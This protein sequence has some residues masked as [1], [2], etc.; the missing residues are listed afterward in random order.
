MSSTPP[1]NRPDPDD[2]LARIQAQEKQRERG[3]LK[4][5]FGYAAGVGKTYA[6][7]EA[8]HQR[9]AEGIDVVVGYVET[10]QRVETENM[11]QGL[12]VIPPKT[13][14]YRNIDLPEMD[15]DQVLARKPQLV[16]VDELAH[17]NAPGS[18][19]AKRYQDVEELLTTGI[20]VY[21]T[22]NIQH[23][24]SLND[25]VAQITGTKV[26]ET[27]PDSVIDEVTDIELIDLP[28]DELLNR[29][30]EGKVYV[31]EQA[32]RAIEKFF[33]QGN[34][35]ALRELTMRRAAE[36]V[37]D[38]MLSYMET[39]AISGP[40]QAGERLLVC[41]SPGSV[42]ERLIRTARRLADELKAEWSAIYVETPQQAGI[43][44]EQR[45]RVDRMLRLAEDLGAKSI[46]LP[47]QSVVETV[48]NYARSHNVTKIIIGKSRR[49]RWEKLLRN[50]VA[51]ELI[52]QSGP[53]D[54][55][56]VNSEANPTIT[57]SERPWQ[58]HRPWRRYL[59]ATALVAVAT[60]I[61]A[62]VAPYISPTNLVVI[63]LL[64]TV[65][66]AIFLGRG[67]AVLAS[68]LSVAAFDYFFVPP[69]LTLAV[70]D[71]EYI[72]T[73]FGL[74]AVSLVISY[75][76]A[77]V[78]EQA[79]AAQR[80][81]AQTAAL[82]ELGHDLTATVGLEAVAKTII[83]HISQTFSRE[84]AIFLPEGGQLKL[85]SASPGLVVAENELAVATWTFE[86][87]Q[88]AG[89]GTDTLPDASMHY[90][91][92]K[93][94][95]GVIGVLG[96][97]PASPNS[98]MSPDQ[99]RTLDAFVNQVALAIEG[100]RLSEQARQ[101]ELLEAT[102]KLQTALLNSISH[103][104][105]T[106]LVSITGALSSLDEDSPALDEEVRRS[107]IDTAREEAERLNRL[108]G[109]LLDISRLE[110]GAMHLHREACDVQE[111]IGSSLEQIGTPL[112]NRQVKV[113][114]SPK[115]P[116]VD[117]DFVLF[118]RVLVNVI[119]NALKYSAPDKPVEI[120]AHSS[121]QFLDI[122]VADRGEGIPVGDLERIFDKFYRVQRPDNVSGTGLG[123]SISKGI[124]EA[125]GGCIQAAN[126]R[127]GGAII[128][129]RL[130]LEGTLRSMNDIGLR[131]LV[132][133]D[134]R[135]IRRYLHAALNAQGYTVYEASGGK[136]AVNMVVADRPDLI[137][138]DL[139]L[140]DMDGVEV[141]RQLREWTHIPIIVLSVREQESDKIDALDAG[142]DDYLTK[143]FSSGELM[144]R[145]RAALRRSMDP[146][147]EPVFKMD[148]LNVDLSRRQVK[149]SGEEISLTPTEYDLL[150]ILVQ[151][152]G[153]VLTH[154]QLLRQVW[155]AAYESEAHLLRVNMSNLRRK[156]EP[157]PTRPRYIITEPGVGYRLK[158]EA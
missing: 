84:V 31:P 138:L 7:L 25:V 91:P 19:H 50:S 71:T 95:R 92:L 94:T 75:L 20:N 68:V 131:V 120:K 113:D 119:D 82:Y 147:S 34:L 62:L 53:I 23:L 36:R 59:W 114:I 97:K 109:N 64:S 146:A 21:T 1:V 45:D 37:D 27:I 99:R 96:V 140:P 6:M 88:L 9:K 12:E 126:R 69:H 4:I 18:R 22:L 46:S 10:H 116:L 24:E 66:A 47:G 102:E 148:N 143:P 150:R 56:F 15:I 157:D 77:Q 74:L 78:R 42:S 55:Y 54:V 127:G 13:I 133:D 128:T 60:G 2:L 144:A 104:L 40:W 26:R 35:T 49:S 52:R 14:T 129:V 112:K 11:L 33:R 72:L 70:T 73:F 28:T 155:G 156:I 30:K 136:D 107:L 121:S 125:H 5:F 135:A 130:P 29:L 65:L 153:R 87:G 63:Y 51:D 57:Q 100:A 85:Y 132:V 81:E 142:A 139:G 152:A 3:H 158:A 137:I 83:S 98:Y 41:I 141:T 145:M 44:A 111:L 89:R 124:V 110:A 151:N 149:V 117:V 32:E 105:R 108:V 154:R 43:S 79:E 38:Q 17:T 48:T 106:P 67:P 118:S 61:G 134:E 101:T 8:A 90:Q 93:T 80:R 16:L 122:S 115:L 58:P 103:D 76:T 39:R 86:H 123:L